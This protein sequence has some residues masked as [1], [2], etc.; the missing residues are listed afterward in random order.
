M[1][2]GSTLAERVAA[3]LRLDG[4]LYATVSMD[5]AAGSQAWRVVLLSGVSNGL[6]LSRQ[7]GGVGVVAGVVAAILGWVLWTAVISVTARVVRCGSHHG[8]LLRALGFANAPG[9]FLVVGMVPVIGA[10]LRAVIVIW[11][12]ATTVIAVQAVFAVSRWRAG[13]VAVIGFLVYLVLGAISGY[14]MAM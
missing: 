7:L 3:A 9:L 8:S 13:V 14:F 1:T 11:L 4:E 2:D 12:L 10:A 6:G 5:V